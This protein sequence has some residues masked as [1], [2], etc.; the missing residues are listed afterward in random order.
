MVQRTLPG[1]GLTGFWALGYDGWKDEND[2]NLRKLSALTVPIVK[3]RVTTLPGSPTDGDIYIVPHAAGSHPDEIAIR[4]DGA[5]VYLMPGEGWKA[6]VLDSN[7]NVQFDGSVWSAL[8]VSL[9]AASTTE[10]L[11]GTDAAKFVTADALAALW[12][13]GSDVASAAT[14]SLG[15]GGF[16]H[17]TGTTTITDID[18]ATAKDGRP[19]WIEFDGVL[20]ITHHA[21]TLV[22]LGGA[23]ITTEAGDRALF[24]QDSS[25]NVHMLAYQRKSGKPLVA[26]VVGT[27]FELEVAISDEATALTTGD[28]KITFYA[29]M[30]AT[31][32]EVF[33]GLSTQSS[34]G[35]VTADLNKNGSTMFS[36]KPSID[37]SEDTSLT[38]TAAVLS[39]TTWTKGDKMVVDLDAA[40][41]GAKGLK[42]II[43]GTRS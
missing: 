40:G 39:T 43:R 37:A 6:Y 18:W 36:T 10:A 34:S 41:T 16:F 27:P 9:S 33:T 28:A 8:T 13:K 38:G 7:E 20:T 3:S 32:S 4:D 1:L 35:A 17:V 22:C 25:D 29:P 19:A 30:D 31:I 2:V 15:E 24:I 14:V 21:T 23:S 42:M 11:T 26:S 12:E 5:W